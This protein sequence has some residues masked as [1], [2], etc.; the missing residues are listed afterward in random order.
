[1]PL[2]AYGL[3]DESKRFQEEVDALVRQWA[4][5]DNVSIGVAGNNSVADN[6]NGLVSRQ[7]P[8]ATGVGN[9]EKG[10]V[11]SAGGRN[12]RQKSGQPHG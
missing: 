11:C 3:D 1:M 5:H 6:R 7:R 2:V 12:L 10:G 4:G 9:A 8:S